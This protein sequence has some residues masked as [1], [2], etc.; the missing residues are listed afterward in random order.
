MRRHQATEW[1]RVDVSPGNC[2]GAIDLAGHIS[3][4]RRPR[5]GREPQR[6]PVDHD[7]AP[8]DVGGMKIPS[9]GRIRTGES[10]NA[11]ARLGP[12][13]G[14]RAVSRITG[15]H[16]KRHS[17]ITG[18]DIVDD[19]HAVGQLVFDTE[20]ARMIRGYQSTAMRNHGL[21]PI[22]IGRPRPT[23]GL[24]ILDHDLLSWKVTADGEQAVFP[25]NL[26]LGSHRRRPAGR[27]Q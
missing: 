11:Y 9:P 24:Q 27:E 16:D 26:R 8:L 5:C 13:G 7:K 18:C 3:R 12:R 4:L 17:V 14:G 25:V 10:I 6:F 19:D 21:G 22:P 2:G 1:T 23:V 20:C 15:R